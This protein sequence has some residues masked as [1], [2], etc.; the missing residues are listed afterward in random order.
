[1]MWYSLV[2]LGIIFVFLQCT[3]GV[4]RHF[5]TKR[6]SDINIEYFFEKHRSRSD[7]DIKLRS[8]FNF[9]FK[10]QPRLRRQD[11]GGDPEATRSSIPNV[12]R[13]YGRISYSGEGSK[14]SINRTHLF[15]RIELGHSKWKQFFAKTAH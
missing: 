12:H 11:E 15:N 8:K 6:H 13:A 3:Q 10:P 2:Q 7:N 5:N 1:M 9:D 14:V 4:V